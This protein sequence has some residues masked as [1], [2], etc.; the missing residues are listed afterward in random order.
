MLISG[1]GTGGRGPLGGGWG[2]VWCGLAPRAPSRWYALSTLAT[3]VGGKRRSPGA[4]VSVSTGVEAASRC[5][6]WVRVSF[7]HTC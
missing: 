1:S 5:D 4:G 7:V 6:S 3:R 2:S